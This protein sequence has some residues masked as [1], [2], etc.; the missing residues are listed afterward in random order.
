MKNTLVTPVTLAVWIGA[1]ALFSTVAR[2]QEQSADTATARPSGDIVVRHDVEKQLL[3]IQIPAKN[4]SVAW[5]DVLQAMM[6]A[7]HLNDQAMQ[8]KM[9][10]GTLDLRAPYSRYAITAVNLLLGPAIRMQI[11]AGD[12][13][14]EGHLLV[15]ID[16]RAVLA[17]K[18]QVSER[19]RDRV[20]GKKD[21]PDQPAASGLR[22]PND[23]AKSDERQ[24]LVIVLHGF[25]SSPQRFEP[26]AEAFRQQGL[27]SGT[28]SYPDDQPISSSAAQLSR[29]LKKIASEQP[30][31]RIA[32]V[33]HSMGGLVARAAL[34]DSELD[35]GNVRQLI[36]VA[37]P[38]HGSLLARIAYG[39]DILDHAVPEPE[40][41]EV[42]RF[43]V[44][45]EDGLS[46]ATED[47][48]P[49]SAFLRQLNSRAR[50]P[51][52]RYAIFLGTGGHFTRKQL[53]QLRQGLATA[54]SKSDVVGLFAP[55]IA[56]T[57]SDLDEVV[58]GL[59]DGVVAVRRGKLEGVDDI[60]VLEFT[61]LRVLQQATFENDPLFK[62][63]LARLK[64][65]PSESEPPK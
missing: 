34:E 62:L 48:K 41:A 60:V 58:H 27:L 31:R 1:L 29:D 17:K 12:R 40:R 43:Y 51:R 65:E 52:V 13:D 28:Y 61:H 16:E 15:T 49:D 5:S 7:G 4:G 2:G 14:R 25:N 53:D 47:L 56:E 35:P 39:L 57:L 44:A 64:T 11:V 63:V 9:P 8:D 20:T 32:L 6:Q 42:S 38:N 45:I 59:G 18:R 10:S 3:H 36:M 55:R 21:D 24:L 46:E 54:Q 37:P 19:I 23:W 50:N 26:L 22:L 33:T 30:K